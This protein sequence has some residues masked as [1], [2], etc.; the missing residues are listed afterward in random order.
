MSYLEMP[1]GGRME[2]FG[3]GGGQVLAERLTAT[4]GAEVPLLGQIPLDIQLREGGDAGVPIVLG[5]SGTPAAAAL[6]GI[7]GQL[8]AKPR[9][10]A[11]MKLGLQ[12]R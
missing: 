7:A 9:G 5:Q 3:S 11:G 8:A 10:L 6:S 2:L 4:V 1:D 12:P